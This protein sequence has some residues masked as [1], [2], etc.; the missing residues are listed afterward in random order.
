[1]VQYPDRGSFLYSEKGDLSAKSSVFYNNMAGAI[2]FFSAKAYL[3][4]FA[5]ALYYKGR[6]SS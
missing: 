3:T 4:V 6:G 5:Y 1:M 2:Q